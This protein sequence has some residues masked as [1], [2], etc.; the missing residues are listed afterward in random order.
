[1]SRMRVIGWRGAGKD[2]SGDTAPAYG[3]VTCGHVV[4]EGLGQL[5]PVSGDLTCATRAAIISPI[6][7]SWPPPSVATNDYFWHRQNLNLPAAG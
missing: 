5:P 4:P 2:R 1:M 7:A 3:V 6:S